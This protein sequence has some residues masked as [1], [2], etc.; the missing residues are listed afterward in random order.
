MLK[1]VVRNKLIQIMVKHIYNRL[2]LSFYKL[3]APIVLI[4]LLG[5]FMP[6]LVNSISKP[7]LIEYSL[8]INFK[9]MMTYFGLAVITIF[10]TVYLNDP[11]RIKQ[12]ADYIMFTYNFIDRSYRYVM[13]MYENQ[14][15]KYSYFLQPKYNHSQLDDIVA[16][17]A[18]INIYKFY[19]TNIDSYDYK[20]NPIRCI[21][22][23]YLCKLFKN[24]EFKEFYSILFFNPKCKNKQSYY[25]ALVAS[26]LD[27]VIHELYK[28]PWFFEYY[29]ENKMN[30]IIEFII[31]QWCYI[32]IQYNLSNVNLVKEK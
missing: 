4:F 16:N 20:E 7:S 10:L 27:S 30:K 19:Y 26:V 22:N 32:A 17:L 15:P 31:N 5:T 3:L 21:S 2:H 11:K 1:L 18:L 8:V 24:K 28:K 13:K 12:E 6:Y 14:K 25:N 29:E 23:D 9:L